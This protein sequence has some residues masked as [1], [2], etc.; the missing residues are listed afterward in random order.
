M[1]AAHGISAGL[2]RA[3]L[4]DARPLLSP[5]SHRSLSADANGA[6][7]ADD[8][9]PT[10]SFDAPPPTAEIIGAFDPVARSRARKNE[11]PP[12]RYSYRPPRY[13]RGPLHPHQPPR[14]SDPASRVFVPG[15]FT[16][17]RLEQ[18]YQSTI[19]PDF[20]TLTYVHQPPGAKA[21]PRATRLRAWD[22]TSPYHANRPL[23]GPRGSSVLRLLKKPTTFRNVPRLE[24]ITVHSMVSGAMEDTAHLHAAGMVVQ[25]MTGVRATACRSRRQVAQ[26]GLRA[27]KFVAVK[28]EL[29]GEDMQHFLA[30]VVDVVMPRIKDWRGVK[31]SAG[32]SSGNISFG[33]PPDGV[34]LFPEVEVNYD[35]YPPKLIPGCHV[36]LHTS[37]TNDR[38]ARLLLRALGIPFYGKLVD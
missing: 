29:R 30:K 34:A 12:S 1:A 27:G 6:E 26:W 21:R 14:P 15:P 38:D 18:T 22:D 20:M 2:R 28:A 16:L 17:P 37:A 33:L 19:A 36:T 8:V 35:M 9:V 23:R 10:S 24:R 3:L 32:D 31:G 11:L 4:R 7:A 5:P 13:Y 25:A